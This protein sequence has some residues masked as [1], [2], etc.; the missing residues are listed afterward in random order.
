MFSSG[1]VTKL[2]TK[3]REEAWTNILPS[4]SQTTGQKPK[5][6]FVSDYDP[7]IDIESACM[8]LTITFSFS[9]IQ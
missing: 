5:A 2:I 4:L 1:T 7:D 9:D 3:L 8:K 6:T